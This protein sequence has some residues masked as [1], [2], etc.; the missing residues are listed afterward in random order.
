MFRADF[1]FHLLLR[2]L[3]HNA[4]NVINISVVNGKAKACSPLLWASSS[5][6]R[7]KFLCIC[8]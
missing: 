2:A 5:N 1:F 8:F 4:I 7:D 6:K 3:C